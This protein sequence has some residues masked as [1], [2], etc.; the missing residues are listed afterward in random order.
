MLKKIYQSA[1]QAVEN[2]A[3]R[4][5]THDFRKQQRAPTQSVQGIVSLFQNTQKSTED[6]QEEI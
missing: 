6:V 5:Y 3:M 4:K 2:R 1:D